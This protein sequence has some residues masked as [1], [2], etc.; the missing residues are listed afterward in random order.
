MCLDVNDQEWRGR[1]GPVHIKI[2]YVMLKSDFILSVWEAIEDS[3][4]EMT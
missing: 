3:R 4:Q 1:Q 2:L